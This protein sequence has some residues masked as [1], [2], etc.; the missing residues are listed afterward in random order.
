MAKW[1]IVLLQPHLKP[2]AEGSAGVSDQMRKAIIGHRFMPML[3]NTLRIAWNF[4]GHVALQL[5]VAF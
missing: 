5:G 2:F 4:S 3:Q 1:H